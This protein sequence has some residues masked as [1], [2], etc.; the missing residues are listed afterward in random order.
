MALEGFETSIGGKWILLRNEKFD[1]YLAAMGIGF[2]KRKVACAFTTTMELLKVGD[3]Q[4]RIVT[5]GPKDSD[6]TVT[7]GNEVEEADPFDNM[8]KATVSW[9][10]TSCVLTTKVA[11]CKAGAGKNQTVTRK[12]VNNELVMQ[13]EIHDDK[14]ALICKRIFK[15]DDS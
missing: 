7:L 1:E 10:P 14:D 3:N 12:I 11:P 8:V 6:H 9:D 5:K 2:I 15:K 13:I 4:I